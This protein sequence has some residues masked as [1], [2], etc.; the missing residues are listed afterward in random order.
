MK[1][2]IFIFGLTSFSSA[3]NEQTKDSFICGNGKFGIDLHEATL[4]ADYLVKSGKLRE[5]TLILLPFALDT[6]FGENSASPY[7]ARLIKEMYSHQEIEKELKKTLESIK[8]KKQIGPYGEIQM[9]QMTF[10]GQDIDL[11]DLYYWL[12]SPPNK[13]TVSRQEIDT[14]VSIIKT[15][16]KIDSSLLCSVLR[17]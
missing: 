4:A 10:F 15:R 16:E 7:V 6:K 12:G 14:S 1:T 3:L 5:A 2:F 17:S 11:P 8:V 13:S 9:L